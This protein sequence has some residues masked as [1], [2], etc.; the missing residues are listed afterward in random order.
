VVLF[1]SRNS[2][3]KTRRYADSKADAAEE[4][5][6]KTGKAIKLMHRFTTEQ[7]EAKMDRAEGI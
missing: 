3:V 5:V 4:D 6:N 1:V 2:P 7:V